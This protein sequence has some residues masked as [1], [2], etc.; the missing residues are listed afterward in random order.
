M[1][2]QTEHDRTLPCPACQQPIEEK[3]VRVFCIYCETN[4]HA[5]CIKNM[6]DKC[7]AC[8]S[9]GGFPK[10]ETGIKR[11]VDITKSKLEMPKVKRKVMIIG[12]ISCGIGIIA[13]LVC[14]IEITNLE[15]MVLECKHVCF[16]C[17]WCD[18]N[19]YNSIIVPQFNSLETITV[20]F[21]IVIIA[22]IA[23]YA[24]TKDYSRIVSKISKLSARS[25]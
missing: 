15:N 22:G 6:N 25:R 20:W 4:F 21:T 18:I 17:P 12:L 1:A 2:D 11:L 19:Y 7:M 16:N 9:I 3:D 8:G 13:N 23:I 10:I 5:E 14:M 24:I